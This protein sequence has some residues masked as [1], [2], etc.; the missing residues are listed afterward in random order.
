MRVSYQFSEQRMTRQVKTFCPQ[1]NKKLNRVISRSYY[2]NGFHNV[3]ETRDKYN[4]ELNKEAAELMEKGVLC[5]ACVDANNGTPI[6]KK[7]GDIWEAFDRSGALLGEIRPHKYGRGYEV[8]GYKWRLDSLAE[9]AL[10]L[11]KMQKEA[12]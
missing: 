11:Q 3:S 1:C 12:N 10:E 6:V 4:A 9:A 2:N 8:T 5:G 7:K